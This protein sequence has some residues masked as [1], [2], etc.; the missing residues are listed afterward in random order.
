[1]KLQGEFE[2][3]VPTLDVAFFQDENSFVVGTDSGRLLQCDMRTGRILRTFEGHTGRVHSVVVT[4]NH[5]LS[6]SHDT[7]LRLWDI[8]RE[9]SIAEDLDASSMRIES[10]LAD[11]EPSP[12]QAFVRKDRLRIV[13]AAIESLPEEQRQV[14]VLRYWE[15]KSNREIT[16]LLRKSIGAVYGP[17]NRAKNK[18]RKILEDDFV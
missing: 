17:L 10:F 15:G 13:P 8:N 9:Q 3:G 5:I 16:E 7:T 11:K 1:M 2:H 6:A 14:L 12:S 18:L 4:G